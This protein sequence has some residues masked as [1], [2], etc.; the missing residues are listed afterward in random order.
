MDRERLR[1]AADT[2]EAEVKS[3]KAAGYA[4]ADCVLTPE[5]K[6]LLPIIKAGRLREAVKLEFTAGA[7]RQ[8]LETDLGDCR[9]LEEA[10]VRFRMAVEG[11]EAKR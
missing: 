7:A 6:A 5:V 11:R 8:F 4:N 2:L 9:A 10:W 1:A 3:A